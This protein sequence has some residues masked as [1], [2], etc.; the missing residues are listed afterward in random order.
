MPWFRICA[1]LFLGWAVLF[2]G[3]PHVTND[4]AA[5]NYLPSR[6]A[7]DWTRLVGLL[8]FGFAVLLYQA[9][10]ATPITQVIASRAVIAFTLP[11]AVLMA[12]WQLI[13]DRRWTRF[14]IGN[15]ALLLI[16]TIVLAPVAR[17]RAR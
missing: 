17:H 6:H 14:D 1:S 8:C 12:Y 11:C 5:I 9:A 10:T 4:L 16:I 3:F 15:I 7:D 13:P 2:A